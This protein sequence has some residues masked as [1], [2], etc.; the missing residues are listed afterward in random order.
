MM[1]LVLIILLLLKNVA[2]ATVITEPPE[3]MAQWKDWL[4]AG[5]PEYRCPYFGEFANSKKCVW[6]GTLKLKVNGSGAIF[7][8]TWTVFEES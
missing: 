2:L 7:Y 4:A 5:F 6:P 3:E 8:Q 1:R